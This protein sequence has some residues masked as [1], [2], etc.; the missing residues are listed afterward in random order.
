M[1][2]NYP[3]ESWLFS[4]LLLQTLLET[5]TKFSLFKC[6]EMSAPRPWSLGS[7]LFGLKWSVPFAAWGKV[8]FERLDLLL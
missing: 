2:D 5:K 8:Q 4:G 6:R 1:G 3:D 7:H